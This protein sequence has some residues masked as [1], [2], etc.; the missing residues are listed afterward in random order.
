MKKA[1]CGAVQITWQIILPAD[2][3]GAD[4]GA[5]IFENHKLVVYL[6]PLLKESNNL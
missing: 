1:P 4:N 6:H 5:G 2:N 3:V